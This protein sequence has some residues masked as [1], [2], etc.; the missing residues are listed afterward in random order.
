MN[1]LSVHMPVVE[2]TQERGETML[3]CRVQGRFLDNNADAKTMRDSIVRAF[4]NPGP[5]R[6]NVAGN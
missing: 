2:F 5:Y 4:R 6:K 1:T 3:Y